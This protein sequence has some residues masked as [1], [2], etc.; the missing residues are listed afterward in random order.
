MHFHLGGDSVLK[1]IPGKDKRALFLMN[2]SLSPN[3]KLCLFHMEF[4]N[5]HGATIWAITVELLKDVSGETELVYT[6]KDPPSD[7]PSNVILIGITQHQDGAKIKDIVAHTRD[8]KRV[9][10]SLDSLDSLDKSR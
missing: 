8:K 1:A 2:H 3:V 4:P 9:E 6:Y 7:S 5:E 10:V